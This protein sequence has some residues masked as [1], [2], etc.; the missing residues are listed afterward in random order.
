MHSRNRV[1]LHIMLLLII[2]CPVH[3]GAV[4]VMAAEGESEKPLILG[5]HPYLSP[6]ELTKR[7]TPLA[8]LLEKKLGREVQISIAGDYKEHIKKLLDGSVDL[9]YMGPASYVTA[10]NNGN[11]VYPLAILKVNDKSTFRGVIIKRTGNTAIE[12]LAHLKGKSFAFGDVKSTMSHLVPRYMLLEAGIKIEELSRYEHLGSH[13]NVALGVLIGDFDA[14]A[15]KEEIFWKFRKRGLTALAMT[16]SISEHIFAGSPLLSPEMVIKLR[17]CLLSIKDEP[18]G[19][20]ALGSIKKGLDS[21]VPA[22]DE[23][24]DNLRKI[25]NTLNHPEEGQ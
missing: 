17:D 12:K 1:I 9:A 18:G 7:F 19:P 21:L 4:E 10:S 2:L 8:K 25:I 14:G 24:Y 23:A 13:E 6:S 15:V 20:K 16:P 3:L 11:N 22:Q 5:I